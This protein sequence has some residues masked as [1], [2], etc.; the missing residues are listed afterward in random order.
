MQKAKRLIELMMLINQKQQFTAR[1]L[2]EACGVSLRTIQR[3]LRDLR[4]LGVPLYA[5]FGPKGGYRLLKEKLLPP[6]TFTENEAVAMFF[7]YQSLHNYASVL[8]GRRPSRR[9]PSSTVFCP[10]R[11]ADHRPSEGLHSVLGPA[12]RAGDLLLQQLLRRL[13]RGK[14]LRFAMIRRRRE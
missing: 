8:F 13:S 5:E 6:L 11:E 2:A 7:A 10:E 1:E 4:S 3:D 14:R 12:E 9:C